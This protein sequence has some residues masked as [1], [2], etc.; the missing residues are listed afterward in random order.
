M[1][2]SNCIQIKEEYKHTNKHKDKH[3]DTYTD[4][5]PDQGS[6]TDKQYAAK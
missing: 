3:R 4:T 2:T 6:M 1:W 5:D